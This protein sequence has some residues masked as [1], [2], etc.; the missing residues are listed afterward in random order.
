MKVRQAVNVWAR[1]ER[2]EGMMLRTF[3]T[4]IKT[5]KHVSQIASAV[6]SLQQNVMILHHR[7]Q[8]V[9]NQVGIQPADP[10]LIVPTKERMQA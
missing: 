9:E 10:Q 3:D 6:M 8:A 1:Q 2:I 7:L 5:G 4:V